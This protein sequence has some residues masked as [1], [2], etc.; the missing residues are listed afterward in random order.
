LKKIS[1]V[2][3]CYNEQENVEQLYNIIK[4]IFSE[5]LKDYD[6]EHLF[7]DNCSFDN[8]VEIISKLA[9]QDKRVKLIINSRN[10]GYVKS[11]Y[12][13][14]LQSDGDA[15][16]GI[17]ADFQDPPELIP[18]FVKKWEEGNKIV[19]GVKTKSKE[20]PLMFFVRKMYYKLVKS[21]SEVELIDNFIGFGLYD[22]KIIEILREIKEPY[23]YF[24]G[25]ICEIGFKKAVV[26]YTQRKRE[27]GISTSNFY[28]LYDVAMLGITSNSK[29]PLR[30]ATMFGFL[31][32]GLS[33]IVAIIYFILKL[34]FWNYFYLGFAPLVIGFFFFSSVQLFFIGI[35]GE[36]IATINTRI[37]NRPLVIE[38]KRI[39]FDD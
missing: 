32:S 3:P 2:T 11:P 24:R 22:R 13:G 35:I 27:K 14:L 10:F 18:E 15:T 7:I 37:I 38:E 31:L 33:F 16:I 5:K 30:M 36:Y 34:L 19:V 26:E 23:P 39:N 8:T 20:N 25:L 29:V 1:I 9:Q 6:Y 4:I 28:M 12:Y 21:I 17:A